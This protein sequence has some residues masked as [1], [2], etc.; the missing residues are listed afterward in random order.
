VSGLKLGAIYISKSV[1]GASP[2]LLICIL[3]RSR[4]KNRR[5][6]ISQLQLRLI[7]DIGRKIYLLLPSISGNCVVSI[8]FGRCQDNVPI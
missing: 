2:C 8:S 1:S 5:N 4:L 6:L 3:I 7:N